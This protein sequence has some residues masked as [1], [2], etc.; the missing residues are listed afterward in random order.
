MFPRPSALATPPGRGVRA[1][2]STPGAGWREGV[3]V[4]ARKRKW[5]APA[6]SLGGPARRDSL[7]HHPGLPVGCQERHQAEV[8]H[9]VREEE[10]ANSVS[11]RP[12]GRA[13]VPLGP[14]GEPRTDSS[15]KQIA[16]ETGRGGAWL[17]HLK[18][19]RLLTRFLH[20]CHVL[21]FLNKKFLKVNRQTESQGEIVN[22]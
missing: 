17:R 12:G 9:A 6:A 18:R 19:W 5:R 1:P 13:V 16:S 11:T 2:A 10:E 15:P 4:R 14:P 3:L 22:G 7:T 20:S 8:T 21:I